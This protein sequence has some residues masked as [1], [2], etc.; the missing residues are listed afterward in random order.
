MLVYVDDCLLID[1]GQCLAIEELNKEYR[2]K[3][4]AYRRPDRYLGAT[5][6]PYTCT[7]GNTYWSMSPLHYLKEEC[8]TVRATSEKEGRRDETKSTDD[9]NT[10][11]RNRRI[12]KEQ[13]TACMIEESS[14][15]RH[16]SG[17]Q[18]FY[19]ETNSAFIV[20]VFLLSN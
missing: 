5:T 11:I 3:N 8:K 15:P 13:Q 4:D 12:N 6:D 17:R 7:G 10:Q 16:Q 14:N 1:H 18:I 19:H 2:L 9:T 20:C